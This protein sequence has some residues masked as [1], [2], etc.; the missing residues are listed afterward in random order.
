MLVPQAGWAEHRAIE[1][2]WDD[3]TFIAR[4]LLADSKIDPADIR[5]IGT[6]AIGPCMLPVNE[7]GEPLMNAVLYGVDTARPHRKLMS[8]RRASG[9]SA[10]SIIAA[11]R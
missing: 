2:W 5:A 1:D 9:L 4:K 6:S 10:F 11:M 7:A 8:S 3:V